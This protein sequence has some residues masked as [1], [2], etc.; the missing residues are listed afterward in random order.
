M[1]ITNKFYNWL[2]WLLN[3]VGI[4]TLDGAKSAVLFIFSVALGIVQLRYYYLKIQNQKAIREANEEE[5]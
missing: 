2:T 1:E 5:N 3:L 4:T